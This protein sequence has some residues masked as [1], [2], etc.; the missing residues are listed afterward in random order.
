MVKKF[1]QGQTDTV[2]FLPVSKNIKQP[3][4]KLSKLDDEFN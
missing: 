4:Y 2:P 3:N 1:N